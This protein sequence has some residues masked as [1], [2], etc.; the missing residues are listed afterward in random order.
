MTKNERKKNHLS[1]PLGL[2]VTRAAM[3]QK[4]VLLVQVMMP[5]MRNRTRMRNQQFPNDAS[6]DDSVNLNFSFVVELP[7]WSVM[8]II[9]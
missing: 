5:T 3:I 9:I 4:K 2:E 6:V 7:R 1:T 8:T